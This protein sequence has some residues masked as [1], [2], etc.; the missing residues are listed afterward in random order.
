MVLITFEHQQF[1]AA[2]SLELQSRLIKFFSGVA[3]LTF[4]EGGGI[5]SPGISF[6]DIFF[7]RN[8]SAGYFFLKLPVP[9]L[10]SQMVGPLSKTAQQLK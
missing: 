2:V 8:H 3:H 4:E 6:K 9:F 7:P 5:F 1:L 10:K